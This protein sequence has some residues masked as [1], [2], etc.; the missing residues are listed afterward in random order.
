MSRVSR[1]WRLTFLALAGFAS[2]GSP[3]ACTLRRKE[4][5]SLQ[6]AP[7]INKTRALGVSD[8]CNRC[9]ALPRCKS[10][11]FKGGGA[12]NSTNCHLKGA[13]VPGEPAA[14]TISGWKT[15]PSPP[16]SDG[17]HILMLF[18]D[19]MDGRVLDPASRQ[20][21]PP[22][23]N[24]QRLAAGGALFTTAYA[25]SPQCVPSRAALMTGRR[26]HETGVYDNYM[27]LASTAGD[28]NNP[29]RHCVAAYGHDACV[30]AGARQN[31][32]GTW[33][34][35]L[36]EHGY[37]ITLYGKM[38][39]GAGL[40]QYPGM[41]NGDGGAWTGAQCATTTACQREWLRG[42]G[43]AIGLKGLTQQANA[44][45][46]VP[47]DV[48]APAPA[49]DYR[50]ISAC[51][52]DIEAGLLRG[53]APQAQLLYCSIVVPHPPYRSNA[54]YMERTASLDIGPPR[55]LPKPRVHPADMYASKAKG[56]WDIDAVDPEIVSHFRRVYFSMCIEADSLLGDIL[57]ALDRS[58]GARER[59]NIVFISDHG[60]D[61]TE[62]RQN[63]KNNMYESGSRVPI[64]LSG[65]SVKAAGLQTSAL[66]SLNDIFPTLM[67]MA[68]VQVP[69]GLAGSSLLPLLDDNAERAS[70][71]LATRKD[72]V[73]AQYH[74]IYSITGTF[75]LRQ[76][77]YK[78]VAYGDMQFEPN[79]KS[80]LFNLSDDPDELQD[81]AAANP[82]KV[83][84]MSALLMQEYDIQAAD[85][86]A[87]EVQ[88][89][90]FEAHVYDQHGGAEGCQKLLKKLLG[91]EF[92]E[93][94]AQ[95][96]ATWL[97][98]PCN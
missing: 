84:A 53:D 24:L 60:E 85:K 50:T 4:N 82:D 47:D 8:C 80:Q 93:T 58:P 89:K 63:G 34:D 65:P 46:A 37:N 79:F 87:K 27:A 36:H 38:H 44:S 91:A 55:W 97:G 18:V 56:M 15:P 10:F 95:R 7:A 73:T 39:V 32:S 22:L 13:S 33:I 86:Q 28:V 57:D 92:N 11:V 94:D 23:P 74:S 81:I 20:V 90:L 21:K 71:A 1:A 76:G 69:A 67:D 98:R 42:A 70:K 2:S 30:A 26:T 77:D 31:V 72:Y 75:M 61:A 62:H 43:S 29:D 5:W 17:E 54:T 19:E 35:R 6:G 64:I 78:L 14:S 49:T 16:Q 45:L 83:Q 48:P 59:T 51:K 96:V 9:Q 88:R 66:V 3:P 40:T 25:E 41:L 12:R 52:A 68:R